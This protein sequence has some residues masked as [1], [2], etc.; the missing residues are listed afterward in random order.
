MKI[1]CYNFQFNNIYLLFSVSLQWTVNGMLRIGFFT[2]KSI[3]AG[4]EMTFD[5]Q[6][7]RLASNYD[8]CS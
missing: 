6:F 3:K 7:E 8:L 4:T 2:K 1:S 5:Y